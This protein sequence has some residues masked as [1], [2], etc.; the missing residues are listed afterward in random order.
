MEHKFGNLRWRVEH[1]EDPMESPR[2]WD[3]L[4]TMVCWH[5]HYSL[6]D[7][8]TPKPDSAYFLFDLAC[9]VDNAFNEM[10][11]NRGYDSPD[12]I[13]ARRDKILEK[14][15][16]IL[17]LYLYDHSGI[18]MN[19]TGFSCRWD[20]GQVGWIYARR[21]DILRD[22][23]GA[24]YLTK[25]LRKWAEEI[26]RAEV[27]VYDQYLTGDIWGYSIS[28]VDGDGDE[29]DHVESCWGFYGEDYCIQESAHTFFHCTELPQL[30]PLDRSTPLPDWVEYARDMADCDGIITADEYDQLTELIGIYRGAE[31]ANRKEELRRKA[32]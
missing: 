19:T 15:Y 11:K 26:L 9:D 7:D 21:D 27:F 22:N 2:A 3:N 1:D 10:Y 4:G 16:V 5:S 28:V 23:P 30:Y 20:S 13:R 14:H 24:K 32:A 12:D 25:K 31:I 8:I 18:T 6:G 29:V 17:P